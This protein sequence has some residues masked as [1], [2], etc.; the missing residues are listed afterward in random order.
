MELI[1]QKIS[2]FDKEKGNV[3][4][5]IPMLKKNISSFYNGWLSYLNGKKDARQWVSEC[6]NVKS[7]F[8]QTLSE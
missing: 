5:S 3:S 4:Y 6:E 8:L 7:C 1:Q 2:Y